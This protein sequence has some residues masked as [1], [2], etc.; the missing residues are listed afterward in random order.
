MPE[1]AGLSDSAAAGEPV[2]PVRRPRRK[3]I[4]PQ[5]N[6]G[7]GPARLSR[8]ALSKVAIIGFTDHKR[9]AP[10]ANPEW[11]IWGLNDLYLDLPPVPHDRVRW[12]QIHKWL[13]KGGGKFAP[14]PD[15]M[16]DF[17]EGPPHPRDPN[18]PKW[19][20]EA[21]K[22]FPLYMMEERPEVP[23]A[24]QIDKEA[25]FAYFDDGMGEPIKYFTNSI[26]WMIA[27]AIMELAP[28]SNGKRAIEDAELGIWGVDMMM[29][30][31]P[32]SEYGYQRPSCE[33]LIGW[34]RGAGIKVHVPA[35][36]DLCKTAYQYGEAANNP[37]RLRLM[38]KRRDLSKQ[39][40]EVTA[41]LNEMQNVHTQL[42][43]AIDQLD[44]QLRSWMPGDGDV[45]G[46]R[47]PSPEADKGMPMSVL[48]GYNEG[49]PA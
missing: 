27:L 45:R 44:W 42:G 38:A 40:G 29:G 49:A 19:L 48:P 47:V 30:G 18:H 1:T 10:F 6:G 39:R 25:V 35:E 7:T 14:Y 22:V 24:V 12:F 21:A 9:L 16:M 41:Q 13:D 43:G 2:A 33:W 26:T 28:Q 8:P 37:Y 46:G 15:S 5:T 36:S 17:G 4:A 34:A 3:R 11:E 20:A 32:G 23:E 31:G